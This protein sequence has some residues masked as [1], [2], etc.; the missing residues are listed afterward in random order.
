LLALAGRLKKISRNDQPVT[1]SS[2]RRNAILNTLAEASATSILERGALVRV[3]LRQKIYEAEQQ[4]ND[5]YFPLDCVLS[6]VARMRDGSQIEVG[7]IGREGMSA[8]PLLMGASTTANVCY[9]QVRGSAIKLPADL[10]R[11]LLASDPAFR[12]LLDR[13]LQAYVNMLGQLAACNRLHT[14]YERC[15]RWL[16]MSRDRMDLDAIPLTQEFLAMMLG[17]GQSGVAIAAGTLQ[18]A[19]LI[20]YTRG[21]ITIL[22]RTGLESASCE[23]YAVARSQFSGLLRAVPGAKAKIAKTK[24]LRAETTM[25]TFGAKRLRFDNAIDRQFMHAARADSLDPRHG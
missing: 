25:K 22:D 16:L 20:K 23:C 13:Y 5:V 19:G 8:F 21:M 7:T 10:F 2:I 15:A 17:T 14:I 9:C 4:I 12:Q 18:N 24:T 6:I 11:E 1:L 3:A